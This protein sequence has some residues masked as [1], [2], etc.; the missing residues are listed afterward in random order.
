MVLVRVESLF[1]VQIVTLRYFSFSPE[2]FCQLGSLL[3]L[4][5]KREKL[6]ESTFLRPS[7]QIVDLVFNI[8]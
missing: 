2:L 6:E 4:K 8:Q 1:E 3:V 5:D 7:L